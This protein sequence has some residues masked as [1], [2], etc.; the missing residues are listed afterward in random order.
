MLYKM[1]VLNPEIRI[2]PEVSHSCMDSQMPRKTA[3]D[4]GPVVQN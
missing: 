1:K 4:Q 2:I 3:K